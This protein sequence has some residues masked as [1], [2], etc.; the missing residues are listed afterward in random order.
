MTKI[1]E[2]VVYQFDELTDDAKEKAREWFREASAGDNYFSENVIEDAAICAAILGINLRTK[3]VSLMGGGTRLKPCIYWSG[4][5]SQGDG[6]SFEGTY[7]YA[8]GARKAIRKHAP[9]DAELHRI[10]DEL[11]EAQRKYFYAI[12][13]SIETCGW[14]SHSHSMQFSVTAERD[15]MPSIEEAEETIPELMRDFADWIFAQ[16]R[17]EYEY[18]NSD[19]CVD[20]NIR[21]NEYEFGEDGKRV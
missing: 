18:Q 3:R 5:Y 11:Q 9:Q 7:C 13:A 16:L 21:A 2:T 20:E 8:K 10:A 17:Q 15:N 6:A 19:E 14:Y 12:C 1:R 4:F